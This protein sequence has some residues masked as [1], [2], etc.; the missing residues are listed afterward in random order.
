MEKILV[1]GGAGFIGSH[2]TKKL[3]QLGYDVIVMDTLLQGNKL[4]KDI[5]KSI[6]F[7]EE[8]V[9]DLDAVKR[10]SKGCSKIFHFAALLGVDIVADRPVETME[11]EMICMKNIADA[12]IANNIGKIIYASTSGIYGHSAIEKSVTEDV[13]V[14]PRTSYSIAKRFNEIYLAAIFEEVGIESVSLR[15]FNVY[16]QNQDDRMVIPK[17]FTQAVNNKPITVFGD[18]HQT[19][20]FTYIDDVIKSSIE[21]AK[22]SNN[23]SEIY[24]IANGSE[25]TIKD[26]A[27]EIICV[28]NSTS[29]INYIDVPKKRYDFEVERRF[30]NSNKLFSAINYKPNTSLIN[31]LK[32]IYNHMLD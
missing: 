4:D 13:T 31:G 30:G 11:T 5:Y 20:D 24:N 28:T 27:K 25:Y 19:R 18:G 12:T 3:V 6:E 8:D 15:F 21:L 7:I 10:Y 26:L 17:F 9:R 23:S 16:G 2:L 22:L 1:T 32:A 29:K 14:D